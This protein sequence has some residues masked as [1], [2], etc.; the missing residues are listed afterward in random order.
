MFTSSA[1]S[2]TP[3]DQFPGVFH[4][5]LVL[6]SQVVWENRL[7]IAQ[8]IIIIISKKRPFL[9][10]EAAVFFP[11]VAGQVVESWSVCFIVFDF[12]EV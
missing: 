11:A 9:E 5:V 12:L 8:N 10:G 3:A 2:G 7:P 4:A 1:A 6:P